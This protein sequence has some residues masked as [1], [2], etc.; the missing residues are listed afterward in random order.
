MASG[1]KMSKIR[2]S[3]PIVFGAGSTFSVAAE[4]RG[5][6]LTTQLAHRPTLCRASARSL[7]PKDESQSSPSPLGDAVFD[8]VSAIYRSST[9]EI[10][11]STEGS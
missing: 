5:L 7:R 3:S 11:R 2:H 1:R 8:I 9:A 6:S 10:M 4:M